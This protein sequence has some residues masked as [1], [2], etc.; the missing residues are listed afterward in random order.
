LLFKLPLATLLLGGATLA[1]LSGTFALIVG[2]TQAAALLAT[3]ASPAAPLIFELADSPPLPDLAAIQS[4][5]LM[6]ANRSFY[7]AP[8]PDAAPVAPPLPEYRFA[9][10]FIAPHKPA[11]ALLANPGGTGARRVRVGEQLDGWLVKAIDA[12]RVVLQWQEQ[13]REISARIVAASTGLRRVPL[14]RQRMASAGGVQLLGSPMSTMSAPA[15]STIDS[16]PRGRANLDV[17]RLYSPP[18]SN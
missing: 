10:A 5:P 8:A 6:H 15:V 16:A 11:V 13:Q 12:R 2:G 17:P 18:P 1:I 3:P 9:G 7:V 4:Q 14:Q